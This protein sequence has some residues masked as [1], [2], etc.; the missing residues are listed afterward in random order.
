MVTYATQCCLLSRAG[1]L[2]NSKLVLEPTLVD[3]QMILAVLSHKGDLNVR[4]YSHRS[5]KVMSLVFITTLT[6]SRI[7]EHLSFHCKLPASFST[8]PSV[9]LSIFSHHTFKFKLRRTTWWY[10]CL[11]MFQTFCLHVFSF[12][13]LVMESR[14]FLLILIIRIGQGLSSFLNG[15]VY[16]QWH[17]SG[18]K[19]GAYSQTWC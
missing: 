17:G 15:V 14:I 7:A 2:V 19:K 1:I 4:P 8:P 6:L 5:F 16:S 13:W 3:L 18:G 11:V 9:Q 12:T 10:P